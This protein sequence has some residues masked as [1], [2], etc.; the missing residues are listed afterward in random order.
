M[1]N[2]PRGSKP[3]D[4]VGGIVLIMVSAIIA[5]L[6]VAYLYAKKCGRNAGL[7]GLGSFLLPYVVPLVLAAL[8]KPAAA[9]GEQVSEPD[10]ARDG[11]PFADVTVTGPVI[12]LKEGFGSSSTWSLDKARLFCLV[13]PGTVKWRVIASSEELSFHF[14]DLMD[15]DE[16]EKFYGLVDQL[17]ANVKVSA[18]SG[19]YVCLAGY[20]G[21][22]AVFD[23]GKLKKACRPLLAG[24]Y[25]YREARGEKLRQWL[26][27]D[28]EVELRGSLGAAARLDKQG[29]HLKKR[30]VLWPDAGQI[31][32][33]TTNG[34]V[35]HLFVLPKGVSGGMFNLSRGKYSLARIPTRQKLAYAAEC[36]FW[37]TQVHPDAAGE[38]D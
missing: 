20:K 15:A 5:C 35:T 38:A 23:L 2:M 12:Q 25:H 30:S 7:W 9:A 10:G 28:P 29:F 37:K 3:G 18:L 24:L 26:A 11:A 16:A 33:E 1:E 17:T 6:V 21:Y 22:R 36:F 13:L 14:P 19:M 27:G 32:T 31:T 4:A 34:I 8:P